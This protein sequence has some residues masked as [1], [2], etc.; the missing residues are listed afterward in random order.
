LLFDPLAVFAVARGQF[1]TGLVELPFEFRVGALQIGQRVVESRGHAPASA[2]NRTSS[3][4]RMCGMIP[5]ADATNSRRRGYPSALRS[6]SGSTH[7]GSAAFDRFT[8][9]PNDP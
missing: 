2:G 6:A 4:T 8:S 9:G 3:E 7:K 1:G 5:L